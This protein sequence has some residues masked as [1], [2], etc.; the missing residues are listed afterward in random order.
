LLIK[1]SH[2]ELDKTANQTDRDQ[3]IDMSRHRHC[4]AL[5]KSNYVMFSGIMRQTSYHADPE[6]ITDNI[7]KKRLI[8]SPGSTAQE[9]QPAP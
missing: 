4:Y 3:L 1:A 7:A 5:S 2:T 8:L 9:V 6:Q